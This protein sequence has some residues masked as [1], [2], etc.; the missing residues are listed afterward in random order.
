[1]AMKTK[2]AASKKLLRIAQSQLYE[3]DDWWSWSV[4]L[5]GPKRELDAVEFVEYTLHSTFRDPVRTIKTRRN[6]FKLDTGGWGVFPIY[7]LVFKKDRTVVHL[8]HQLE[9]TYPEGTANLK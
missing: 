6:G 7:A 9:L 5:E 2:T 3:G 8:K 4:W 1:M